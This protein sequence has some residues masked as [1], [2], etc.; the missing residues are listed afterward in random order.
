MG[1]YNTA[2]VDAGVLLAGEGLMPSAQG[3]VVAF[4]GDDEPTVSDGPFTEAKELVGGFWILEVDS[5]E[6]A[7][8]VGAPGPVPQRRAP[9]GPPRQRARG[10]RGHR[11]GGGARRRGAS[12]GRRQTGQHGS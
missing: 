5:L 8:V 1:R 12:C 11:P 9:R 2:M 7:A 6:E 4:D 10:L 3:A